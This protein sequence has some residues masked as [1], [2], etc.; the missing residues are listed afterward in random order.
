MKHRFT[1]IGLTALAW[2]LSTATIVLADPTGIL[3]SP[4]IPADQVATGRSG[5]GGTGDFVGTVVEL[6]CDRETP[7]GTRVDCER[8]GHYYALQ[9]DG[10]LALQPI[11]AAT[12]PIS[13]ELRSGQWTDKQVRVSGVRYPSTGAI[14]VGEITPRSAARSTGFGILI[15]DGDKTTTRH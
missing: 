2:M 13:D 11:L 15:D 10:Q 12:K 8:T 4:S 3:T 14:L 9:T 5:L 7:P 6:S 1:L